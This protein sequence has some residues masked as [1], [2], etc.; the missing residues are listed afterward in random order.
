MLHTSVGQLNVYPYSPVVVPS[1]VSLLLD[2]RS[3]DEAVLAEADTLLHQRIAKI[4][5]QA[6]VTVER[7]H[8]HSW[9]ETPYQPEGVE[10]AAKV[11]AGLGLANK[12]VKTLAGHDSTN[13][14]DLVPTVMLLCPAWTGSPTTSTNTPRTRTPW[15]D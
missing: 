6:N 9:P 8:A 15:A 3:A 2:Q 1:R 12:Q 13:M 7:N 14:K 5:E 11:A 10:L 4:E